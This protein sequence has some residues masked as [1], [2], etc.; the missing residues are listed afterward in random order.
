MSQDLLRQV[1]GRISHGPNLISLKLVYN[2]LR[3]CEECSDEATLLMEKIAA[4]LSVARN[5]GCFRIKF[6]G[7]TNF[8]NKLSKPILALAPMDGVTDTA[9]RQ[10]VVYAGKPDVLFTEFTNV[11]GLCSKGRD[12]LME[13]LKFTDGQHPIVAQIWG[14][15]PAKFYQTA[16]LLRGM[17]FD[18]IDIN[19]GCPQRH[20]VK[21]GGGAGLVLKNQLVKEIIEATK[22]GAGGLPV[23]VKTRLG[24]DGIATEEWI[25]FL[26]SLDLP[27]ITIH[28][29]TA[30][31]MSVPLARWEEI[32]KAVQ[33]RNQLG[34]RTLILGNGDIKDWREA[35]DKMKKYG[36]DG[37]MIGRGV[38][39][40]IWLFNKNIDLAKIT[41]ADKAAILLKHL[42][43]HL[44]NLPDRPMRSDQAVGPVKKFVRTYINGFAGAS[45]L[46]QE[47]VRAQ[48][49]EEMTAILTSFNH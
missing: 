6:A 38:L 28:S 33:L 22:K 20:V 30:K 47:L 12:R 3:H 27:V 19:M 37:V 4:L 10:V 25:G 14:S 44:E 23:S 49:A 13:R 11:D 24:F 31:E 29:R 9:F 35:E 5:D 8:W 34:S 15:D 21:V 36:V 2:K 17:K 46:R 43:I 7:M 26:L 48:S 32:G 41:P 45:D 18:G 39:E 40:N 42:Q 1:L 16:K